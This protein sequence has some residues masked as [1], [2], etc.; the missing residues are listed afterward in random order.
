[1]PTQ[2]E[3]RR[4]VVILAQAIDLGGR[5]RHSFCRA[6]GPIHENSLSPKGAACND[7]AFFR[8][9]MILCQLAGGR[10]HEAIFREDGDEVSHRLGKRNVPPSRR[11]KYAGQIRHHEKRYEL[12]TRLHCIKRGRIASDPAFKQLAGY[13]F[14]EAST[15]SRAQYRTANS[16]TIISSGS[17][18]PWIF[19][20]LAFS[21][22][23]RK[24]F[25]GTLNGPSERTKMCLR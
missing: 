3:H 8:R 16:A 9:F 25:A 14:Q 6:A 19:F 7:S 2:N 13:C 1:M 12:T 4:C 23:S 5:N 24:G 10:K 20:T 22:A 21:I 11:A 17:R 18:M 15:E